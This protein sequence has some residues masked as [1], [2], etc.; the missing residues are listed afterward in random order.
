MATRQR[1]VCDSGSHTEPNEQLSSLLT[2]KL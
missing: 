2:V 1:H